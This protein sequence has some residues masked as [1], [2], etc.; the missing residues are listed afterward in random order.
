MELVTIRKRLQGILKSSACGRWIY[1]AVQKCWRAYAIP[2]RR[3]LLQKHGADVLKRI[4][5]IMVANSIPYYCEAGTLLGIIRDNGFIPHDDDVDISI[6]AD[7]VSP[8]NVLDVL[9]RAGYRYL[10]GFAYEGEVFEFTV[11]DRCG[12]SVDFFFHT[13][14]N[15]AGYLI[16]W[17]VYWNENVKYPSEDANSLVRFEF[18]MPDELIEYQFK[19]ITVMIPKNYSD[20]LTSLYGPWQV[21]DAKF[22]TVKD[23]IHK[24]MPGF[25]YRVTVQEIFNGVIKR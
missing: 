3:R 1:P 9:I 24:M 12:L 11:L 17:G 21:P 19:D 4:H 14:S 20:E 16:G 25:A 23:R 15:R 22:D 13:K 8:A 10:H 6:Q 18:V 7:T 5:E 2:R